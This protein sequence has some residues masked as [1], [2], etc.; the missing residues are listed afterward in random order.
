MSAVDKYVNG[1]VYDAENLLATDTTEVARNLKLITLHERCSTTL[2]SDAL[3]D[4]Q[5]DR[6]TAVRNRLITEGFG[7][8]INQEESN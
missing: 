8:N 3:S 1:L 7:I 5:R 6:L 4:E 2:K